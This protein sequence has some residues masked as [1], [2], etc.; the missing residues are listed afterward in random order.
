MIEIQTI[1]QLFGTEN[2]VCLTPRHIVGDRAR[3]EA[4]RILW[5]RWE[6][7]A[8]TLFNLRNMAA[9]REAQRQIERLE[10]KFPNV[11]NLFPATCFEPEFEEHDVYDLSNRFGV[12]H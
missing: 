2:T 3:C 7:A 1:A 6:L 8:L 11:D 4:W 12:W 5:E 10:R 9:T